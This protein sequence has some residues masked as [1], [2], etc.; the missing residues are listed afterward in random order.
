[1]PLQNS[2]KPDNANAEAANCAN[3]DS[4]GP[5]CGGP[6]LH[7]MSGSAAEEEVNKQLEAK[8]I[9]IRAAGSPDISLAQIAHGE[10]VALQ[11]MLSGN[12]KDYLLAIN[13]LSTIVIQRL[14][15]CG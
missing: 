15:A 3:S 2:S 9:R 12:N 1:M 7:N 5:D 4:L 10:E 13:Q 6:A 8:A 14:H 11:A